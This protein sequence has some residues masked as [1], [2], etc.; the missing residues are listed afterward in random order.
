MKKGQLKKDKYWLAI[1]GFD[2]LRLNENLNA[3]LENIKVGEDS[4]VISKDSNWYGA[5]LSKNDLHHLENTYSRIL[6]KVLDNSNYMV[7]FRINDS[8]SVV[9]TINIYFE[10]QLDIKHIEVEYDEHMQNQSQMFD[11]NLKKLTSH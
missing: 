3:F 1:S 11:C 9:K 5:S 8:E 7:G 4:L 6:L 2:H 10:R